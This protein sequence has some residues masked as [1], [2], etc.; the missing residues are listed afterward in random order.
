MASGAVGDRSHEVI[1]ICALWWFRST[2]TLC[3]FI[4]SHRTANIRNTA[5]LIDLDDKVNQYGNRS[6]MR[7][8]CQTKIGIDSFSSQSGNCNIED[9]RIQQSMAFAGAQ[10]RI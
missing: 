5:T 6:L 3:V 7:D 10:E 1:C 2:P 4:V 8:P 9:D